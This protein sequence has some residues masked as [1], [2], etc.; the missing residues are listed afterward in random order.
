MGEAPPV[1]VRR[2]L[3]GELLVLCFVVLGFLD[4]RVGW[5]VGEDWMGMGG[6]GG[7]DV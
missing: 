5:L 7:T 4:G 2:P 3:V 6:D 1:R